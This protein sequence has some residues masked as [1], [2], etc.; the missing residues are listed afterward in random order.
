MIQTTRLAMAM[1]VLALALMG[2]RQAA[3]GEEKKVTLDE[4]PA[5]VKDAL[6]KA[7]EGGEILEIEAEEEDGAMEYEAEIRKDGKVI[8]VEFDAAGKVLEEEEADDDEDEG[9]D[10][11]EEEMIAFADAPASVQAAI[12]KWL[13]DRKVEKLEVEKENGAMVYEAETKENGVEKS[14][15]VSA[16]G[17]VLEVEE[18]VAADDLPAAVKAALDKKFPGASVSEAESIQKFFYEVKVTKDGKTKEVKVSPAGK[19]SSDDD[20]DDDD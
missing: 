14:I 2:A 17:A 9:D 15:E 8:E 4:L 5:T 16:D 3:A 1:L 10:D 19:I 18:S 20:D 6:L 11:D 12:Q 13:G 7:A